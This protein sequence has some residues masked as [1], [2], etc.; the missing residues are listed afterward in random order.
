ARRRRRRR[1]IDRRREEQASRKSTGVA[2]ARN[3]LW[4]SCASWGLFSLLRS[5]E[6]F[7]TDRRPEL[8]F[9]SI[10]NRNAVVASSPG[11]AVSA[12]LGSRKK[13]IQPQSGCAL[14]E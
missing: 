6:A 10:L 14:D 8:W 1:E 13:F 7:A 9:R 4:L 5:C 3:R 2:H 12:T 11:L